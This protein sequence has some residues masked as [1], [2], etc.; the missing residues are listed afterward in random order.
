[1]AKTYTPE[2]VARAV[3]AKC[4]E[5]AKQHSLTKK[6][7]HLDEKEDKELCEDIAEKE[8]DEHEKELHEGKK[9][10][11]DHEKE[12]HKK[13]VKKGGKLAAFIAKRQKG[14][15]EEISRA[16]DQGVSLKG[17]IARAHKEAKKIGHYSKA[18]EL[19]DTA[20]RIH[21]NVKE[22][23]KKIKPNLPKSEVEKCG[24]VEKCGEQK[25]IK[26]TK[27]AEANKA[28]G[29]SAPKDPMGVTEKVKEPAVSDMPAKP[30][31]A[32]T[33]KSDKLKAFLDKKKK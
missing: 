14:I 33:L 20:K 29:L 4:Q 31:A 26:K 6:E 13:K 28:I 21:E 8:V 7:K 3:L 19:K 24:T 18:K 23:S 17:N 5:I 32:T 10:V 22:E 11:E 9:D 27:K 12:M 15:N 1:M 25:V 2:E 30:K 16:V